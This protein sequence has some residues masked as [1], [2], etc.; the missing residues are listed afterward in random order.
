MAF[1][2]VDVVWTQNTVA[3]PYEKISKIRMEAEASSKI[4]SSTKLDS[5]I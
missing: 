4:F 2:S 5:P 3:R 1:Y